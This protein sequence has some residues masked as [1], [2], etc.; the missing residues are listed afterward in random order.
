MVLG[1]VFIDGIQLTGQASKS[2]I[3][4]YV[5][6][7]IAALDDT[8]RVHLKVLATREA[9][10]PKG[11]QHL[12]AHRV[13]RHGKRGEWEHEMLRPFSL[14]A[15]QADV[16]HTPN[17]AVSAIQRKP[18]VATLHDVA[19]LVI[20]DPL[21]GHLRTHML[22]YGRRLSS[23]AAI[24]AISRYAADAGI[25]HLGLDARRVHVVHHG[26]AKRF[27]PDG[28]AAQSE[29]PYILVV[30]EY[31]R[32]KGF[33][34]AFAVIDAL[35]D[36]GYPHVLKVA[37]RVNEWVKTELATMANGISHPERIEFLGYAGDLPALYRGAII[38]IVPSKYEGFGL[39]VLEAMASG[40]PVISFRNSALTEVVGEGGLLA[41]EGDVGTMTALARKLIDDERRREEQIE[42]GLAWAA[43]FSWEASAASHIDIYESVVSG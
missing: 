39:P 36:A 33:E 28:A 2:G 22:R 34:R 4:T 31:Q 26:V 37:G 11:V 29:R 8:G 7:L 19:P 1:S 6:E 16:Y 18:W 30:G 32:R 42:R 10:L 38:T 25:R 3:G 41:P 15:H 27:T 43:R 13:W 40:C 35:A 5:R 21:M 9:D 23:A 14:V 17:F 20:E 24:V 12:V